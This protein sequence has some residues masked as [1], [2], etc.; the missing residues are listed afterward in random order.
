MATITWPHFIDLIN[1]SYH[2]AQEMYDRVI[3]ESRKCMTVITECHY[4]VQEKLDQRCPGATIIPVIIASD[5]T[6]ITL[7]GGKSM[8]PVYITI[9]NI[10][11]QLRKKISQQTQILLA[12]LPTTRLEHVT[13]EA[14]K[15]RMVLNI[16]HTALRE[17]LRPLREA[18]LNGLNL[19][20]GDGVARRTHPILAAHIGDYM[21]NIAIVGCKMGEC[22]RCTVPFDKLGGFEHDYPL[23]DLDKT[24]DA[25][26]TYDTDRNGFAHACC[27]AGIKPIPHPYWEDLPFVNIFTAIPPDILHQLHQGLI[28]HLISWIKKL[29][30]HDQ[31]NAR[32]R[33]LPL[34]SHVRHFWKGMTHLSRPTGQE[35]SEL[36]RVIL[37]VIIDLPLPDGQSPVRLVKATRAL[38]DF[39]YLAQ[40]PVHSSETLVLLHDA[41]DRFHSHKEVFVDLGIRDSWRLPKLHFASHYVA[42][43]KSLGTAD[44]FNTEYTERL[45]IDFAKDAY[46]ATNHSYELPQMTLWLERREKVL[47]HDKL[48]RW[49]EDGCPPLNTQQDLFPLPPPSRLIMTKHPSRKAVP[50]GEL[51]R[52]YHALSIKD[53]LAHFIVRHTDPSLTKAQAEER[54][55]YLDLPFRTLPV[56][57]KARFWV[58]DNEHHRLMSDELNAALAIPSRTNGQKQLLP[59]HF[60][61]V[62][63]NGGSGE[64]L[65]VA[66]YRVARLRVIFSLPSHA[67]AQLFHPN[68]P[69]PRYLAYVEWFTPFPRV[70]HP[71]HSLYH[72]KRSIAIAITLLF[73]T[74]FSA[75]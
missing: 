61:T 28:K 73:N 25:L 32:I 72:I 59:A 69:A 67:A 52:D 37:G 50:F 13:N 54:A 2:R 44:N 30:D 20:S 36:A 6:Q 47:Q 55:A 29:Y 21:E 14:A 64:F 12:Y 48:V 68:A 70:P 10:P 75:S 5:K 22:P 11:K 40:Y 8:Y 31:L 39:L 27:D 56:Y 9:G 17:I 49:R 26:A 15:R 4:R 16:L 65:G 35:H 18:G 74:I 53:A 23:R 3:T 45:H 19:A 62:L 1:H 66:G 43:I 51:V 7:F 63:V 42:L 58:G 33:C 34:N 38:L 71:H 60:D 46:N 57:H 41:L 24:L